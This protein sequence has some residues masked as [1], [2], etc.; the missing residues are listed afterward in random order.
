MKHVFRIPPRLQTILSKKK[1]RVLPKYIGSDFSGN[2]GIITVEG[3]SGTM[4]NILVDPSLGKPYQVINFSQNEISKDYIFSCITDAL[5][6]RKSLDIEASNPDTAFRGVNQILDGLPGIAIDIY[7]SYALIILYS[8]HWD[9]Y[10]QD[11]QRFLLKNEIYP[12]TGVYLSS[13]I[14]GHK[15]SQ[16]KVHDSFFYANKQITTNIDGKSSDS[17]KTPN[18][19]CIGGKKAEKHKVL[20]SENGL[21]Y[22][23]Q[24]NNGTATGLYLDQRDNRKKL[25]ILLNHTETQRYIT[26][27]NKKILNPNAQ[28]TKTEARKTLLNVFSFTCSFGLIAAKAGWEST[29]IDIS[30]TS[31]NMARNY[32]KLNHFDSSKHVFWEKEVFRGLYSLNTQEFVYDVVLVDP[33]SSSKVRMKGKV[34]PPTEETT[35]TIGKPG[36]FTFSSNQNYSSL[37]DYAASLVAPGGYLI[38]FSN[39][40]SLSK[41]DFKRSIEDGFASMLK[42]RKKELADKR[43][44]AH[45]KLLR[46]QEVKKKVRLRLVDQLKENHNF[47]PSDEELSKL[48]N[49]TLIDT[50]GLPKDFTGCLSVPEVDEYLTGFVWKRA[51]LEERAAKKT[52]SERKRDLEKLATNSVDL[53]PKITKS[54]VPTM[55]SDNNSY[56]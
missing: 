18:G 52:R 53:L 32:F 21:K 10:I 23:I 17:H 51:E 49:F 54:N 42:R 45:R 43:M 16:E 48:Y 7:G 27:K 1:I 50:W 30:E 2:E 55:R 4:A 19:L 46:V 20:I 22:E 38:T 37:V 9:Y 25:E 13:H 47:E 6:Y 28:H 11:I 24:L 5:N 8:R 15:G 39:T 26:L 29:N 3:N 34:G 40:H 12:I 33:P 31:L 41:E 44:T 35:K 14:R 36:M 56:V